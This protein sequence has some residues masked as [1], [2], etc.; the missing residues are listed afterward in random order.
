M[1]FRTK[2][3]L[4]IA[5][6]EGILLTILGLSVL[7]QLQDSN[8]AE[9]ERRVATVSRLLSASV[10]DPLIAYDLA[11]LE[12]VAS[13]VLGTGDL[14]YVRVLDAQQN[15]LVAHGANARS[16]F[17]ADRVFEEVSDG[18]YDREA[19]LEIAGQRFGSV[20]FGIDIAPLQALVAKTRLWT[21]SISAL[22]ML[23]VAVFS[24]V[25]GT[26]LT[27]QLLMLRNASQRVARGNLEQPL[28]VIGDD[29]LAETAAAFN[30]M[31]A[32]LQAEEVARAAHHAQLQENQ[33]MLHQA[34]EEAEAANQAKSTFLATMSHELRTP[35]NAILGMAELLQMPDISEAE[36][37]DYADTIL[38][39][40]RNLLMLLNDILDLS[41]VESG[42]LELAL[43]AA[44][45]LTLLQHS[46]TLF[47]ESAR[48]KGLLLEAAWQGPAGQQ[49]IV[50]AHRVGQML[51][52]L[53]GN[54]IKFTPGG[55]VRAEA[56]E[57]E[58]TGAEAL[59]EFSVT[60]TGIGIAE[61][62]QACLFQPFSQA[63]SSITR[64]FGGSGLG[65]SIVRKLALLM[66]GD[67]GVESTLGEGSRFWFRIRAACVAAAQREAVA[68]DGP[69][70][71]AAGPLASRVLVAEDNLVNQKVITAL[72]GRSGVDIT[73]VRNG[74]EALAA[75]MDG[76]PIDIIL[77]DLHMPVM[78]GC[79]A[80][81]RIRVWEAAQGRPP[82]P[83]VALTAD[84]FESDRERCLAA[85]MDDFL[86]KPIVLDALTAVIRRLTSERVGG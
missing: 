60:D 36:R 27:R 63:D 47:A 49:Y 21:L 35:M 1:K 75:V 15:V 6:I 33:A 7:G 65:L 25:L 11:T 62:R 81:E 32:K 58:R 78:D 5:L 55:A 59:L 69:A 38:H 3:V 56:C 76:A 67:A 10:R 18:I 66:G 16:L 26:Y 84:A 8:E 30:L 80:T 17:V 82:V 72:L 22:E 53:I 9:M 2:T 46:E 29:E 54:A 71:A 12:S 50:D 24:M 14:A 86:T 45:P 68:Q 57:L 20:Q 43:D 79:T 74:Q 37:K 64:E 23:L 19:V 73:L 13:D 28:P 77:M 34:K 4:G 40:G 51:A 61:E 39:S 42:H 85:G 52:N 44:D 70:D 83:I 31:V 48:Q 41:K